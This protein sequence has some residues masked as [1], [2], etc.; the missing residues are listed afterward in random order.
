VGSIQATY[1]AEFS[2]SPMF[3]QKRSA[4]ESMPAPIENIIIEPTGRTYSRKLPRLRK[5]R[6][7]HPR[8]YPIQK[9]EAKP[10]RRI[11]PSQD[12]NK[13]QNPAIADGFAVE[14]Q[15]HIAVLI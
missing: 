11:I 13:P 4:S 14:E 15:L 3:Q 6:G 9:P 8:N 7:S 12:R 1:H 10:A 5:H 2:A